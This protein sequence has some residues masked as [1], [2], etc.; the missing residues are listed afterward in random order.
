MMVFTNIYSFVVLN[1]QND[2]PVGINVLCA[3]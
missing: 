2:A 3:L 1:V